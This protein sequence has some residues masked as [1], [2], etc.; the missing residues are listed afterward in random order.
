MNV[1]LGE[2]DLC[3]LLS[4]TEIDLVL[5]SIVGSAGLKP[6]IAAIRAKKDI[7]LAN[8]ETLV[9]AGK[10]IMSLAQKMGVKIIPVDS[11]HSAIFQCLVGESSSSVSKLILTASGGPFLNLEEKLFTK[12]TVEKAL[13][14]PN[15][16]MGS[17]I[18]IDSATLMNKGLELIEAHWLFNKPINDIDVVIHPESII[19]SLVEFN[20]GSLKAQ[21]GLPTMITPILY[22]FSYP[23]RT[24]YPKEVF[25]LADLKS[26]TFFEPNTSKFPHLSL[27]KESIKIGGNAPC[28]LNAANEIAVEAFL[29]KKI[30]FL[31]MIK[32]VEKSLENFNFVENPILEDYYKTDKD[33]RLR[34]NDLIK[35][36]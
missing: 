8:K 12:I 15:W 7:A 9:V 14:H 11:E 21:M 30:H 4:D 28:V 5:T 18:T 33:S 25:S 17:K 16:S 32:I 10:L 26:L 23:K 27:A 3:D 1:L 31:D 20:D 13:K 6:T 35:K 34:A 24:N 2:E 29:N 36:L 19:H 22:A